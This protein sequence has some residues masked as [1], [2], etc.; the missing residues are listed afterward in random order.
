[1]TLLKVSA[2]AVLI[3]RAAA[4]WLPVLYV[5]SALTTGLLAVAIAR[6]PRRHAAAPP[7]WSLAGSAALLLAAWLS[8]GRLGAVG[9]SALYLGAEAFATLVSLRYWEAMGHAFDARQ[10]RRLFTLLGASGMAG[11]VLGGALCPAL[12]RSGSAAALLPASAGLMLL[13]GLFGEAFA[14]GKAAAPVRR[15]PRARSAALD[16]LR[17]DGYVR[18]LSF[19]A[20]LL[21]VLTAVTDYLFRRRAG[22]SLG[23]GGLA[24]LF[25]ELNLVVGLV[26][27]A[28]Q[29]GLAQRVLTR[30]G[31]FRYLTLPPAGVAAASGL[32]IFVPGLSPIFFAKAIEN[33]GSLSVTQSGFQLLYGPIA[34]EL[35]GSARGLVDGLMKKVGF[36]LG[37]VL[38]L[39]LGTRCSDAV[40]GFASVGVAAACGLALLRQKP[41]YV[42]ALAQR[43]TAGRPLAGGALDADA[44]RLLA[45]ELR[46]PEPRRA[47]NALELLGSDAAFDPGPV[48]GPLLAH[49]AERV[50]EAAVRLAASSGA[51]AELPRLLEMAEHEPARRPRDEAVRALASLLPPE[52]ARERLGALVGS[53]DPGLRA[54]AVEALWKLGEAGQRMARE[55]LERTLAGTSPPERRE[56]ARL[57]GRLG[58]DLAA[59]K[60]G[61]LLLDPD[62]S[63]RALACASAAQLQSPELQGTLFRLLGDRATRRAAR[64]ALAAYGDEAVGP[65]WAILDDRSQPL[66]LRL[67]MPRLL[68]YIGTAEA[69]GALLYSNIQDDAFLRYRIGLSLSRWR[70]QNPDL[71]V[72][73]GRVREAIGRRI[74]AYLH[75]LPIWADIRAGLGPAA[76][77]CRALEGRLDQNLEVVFRLLGLIHPHRALLAAHRHFA[78]SEARER[79]QAVELLDSI[80]DDELRARLV[81]VLEGNHRHPLRPIAG[82]GS[83]LA[84]RLDDLAGSRDVLLAALARAVRR[85][86]PGAEDAEEVSVSTLGLEKILLLEGVDIFAGC[87]VDDLSALAAIARERRFAP[88][89]AVYREG[90]PGE[91]LYVIV[92]GS[93]RIEKAGREVLTMG[94]RDTIGSVSLMDGAPRPAD[95]VATTQLRCLAL[96]RGDFLDL[97]ADRPELLKGVFTG[98]SSHLRKVLERAAAQ[99]RA[100]AA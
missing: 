41:R 59:V 90:E 77:L 25:G 97:V 12:A 20:L 89:E 33:A 96:D 31:I 71:P 40:L 8:L 75:Y 10:A 15:P 54:A 81:P 2:N 70:E 50:R 35:Q 58:S 80:L 34:P 28:F 92:D 9:L 66:P 73:Q 11:A 78:G 57:V 68:R 95:A 53:E 99:D 72:D 88:G 18:G 100:S 37:G 44:R 51:V 19:C 86:Q 85:A 49:P 23:E 45:G 52:A 5:L 39:S 56:A 64:E 69:A 6:L 62:S 3:A 13:T 83:H 55:G 79:A 16:L 48:L 76:L 7:S 1:M 30:F 60:L 47:L 36:A 74:D 63:V 91:A 46:S 87:S 65:A 29:L 38:L 32:S 24:S 67:E 61:E 42:A 26:A 17:R 82:D 43:L 22:A 94:A 84:R 93:V 4:T 14:R 21:A 98:L 27:V